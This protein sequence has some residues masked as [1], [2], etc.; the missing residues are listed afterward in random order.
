MTMK[1][2]KKIEIINESFEEKTM[3]ENMHKFYS[4]K[5]GEEDNSKFIEMILSLIDKGDISEESFEEFC[6]EQS[7]TLEEKITKK[8]AKIRKA[9][10]DAKNWNRRSSC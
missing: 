2:I 8:F 3:I 5:Y 4:E 9:K 1:H 10:E 6:M 7:I